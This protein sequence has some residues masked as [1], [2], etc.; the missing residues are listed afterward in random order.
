MNKGKVAPKHRRMQGT[1]ITPNIQKIKEAV[2]L[3]REAKDLVD[4]VLDQPEIKDFRFARHYYAY[5]RY[6]FDQLLGEGNPLD[7]CLFEL[8]EELKMEGL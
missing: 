4:G 3:I 2:D 8:I 7:S 6:G 1:Q 5:G